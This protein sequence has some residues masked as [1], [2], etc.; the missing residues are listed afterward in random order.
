[1]VNRNEFVFLP[2][3]IRKTYARLKLSGLRGTTANERKQRKSLAWQP[4]GQFP[5]VVATGIDGLPISKISGLRQP[6]N[7]NNV[8]SQRSVAKDGTKLQRPS[9]ASE[10]PS[11]TGSAPK[12]HLTLNEASGW[13]PANP[14]L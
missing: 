12:H 3:L 7:D 13:K 2:V 5:K 8:N 9:R 4:A 11:E 10:Y 14:L 1:M 6:F